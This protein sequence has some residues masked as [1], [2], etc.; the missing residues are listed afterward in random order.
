VEDSGKVRAAVCDEW[1]R[2]SS[3][4]RLLEHESEIVRACFRTRHAALEAT[5]SLV[6]G[7]I[8]RVVWNR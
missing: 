1:S 3:W 6:F 7:A 8:G 5:G 2:A 4:I